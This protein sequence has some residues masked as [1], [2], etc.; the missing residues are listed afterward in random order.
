MLF[1]LLFMRFLICS[2]YRFPLDI[3]TVFCSIFLMLRRTDH[4]TQDI[5]TTSLEAIKS[6]YKQGSDHA[7]YLVRNS[8]LQY[9]I[10]C[11]DEAGSVHIIYGNTPSSTIWSMHVSTVVSIIHLETEP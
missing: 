9:L 7:T 10:F 3:P 11:C 5:Y 4:E 2:R 1:S 8:I 6:G